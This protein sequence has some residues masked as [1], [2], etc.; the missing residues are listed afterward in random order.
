MKDNHITIEF[1]FK[2]IL[3]VIATVVALWLVVTIKEVL[4]ILFLAY[5]FAAALDPI[6]DT[7]EKKKLPRSVA[8][9]LLYVAIIAVGVLFVELVVP[10][11]IAQVSQLAKDS[12][13]Y[14]DKISL[15]LKDINPSLETAGRQVL[16]KTLGSLS[17]SNINQI[18][19]TAIGFFTG[20]LGLIAVFVI[21]FYLLIQRDGVEKGLSAILPQKY[22]K[23]AFAISREI[24]KKMSSW[25]RG[26]LFLAFVIFLLNYIALTILH[27][28][29]AL[30][31]ALISGVLELLPIIGPIV[32]GVLAAL[33]ALATSPLLAIIVAIWYIVVQQLENHILVPQIMKKSVGLNPIIVIVAILVGGKVMGFWGVL[34]S[35][36][37]F[38]CISVIFEEFKKNKIT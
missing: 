23:R 7:L 32:A 12:N 6:V 35:V 1:S 31:L 13:L 29:M 21:G 34:I 15:F 33:I 2:T 9:L 10:P 8:I 26:Q 38:A 5:I 18:A 4:V 30:T 19:G 24:A 36:P 27:V 17:G 14:I 16:S 11:T 22:Q 20:A 37:V 28:D 3:W 25:V